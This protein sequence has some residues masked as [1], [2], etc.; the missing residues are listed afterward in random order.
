MSQTK[1]SQEE[2]RR[3]SAEYMLLQNLI[4]ELEQR[5][6]LLSTTINELMT[7]KQTINELSKLSKDH[8]LIVSV[9]RDVY[10]RVKVA[11]S[12]KFLVDLGAGTIVERSTEDAIKIIDSRIEDLRKAL[13]EYQRNYSVLVNRLAQIREIIE[14]ST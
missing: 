14:K 10:L 8:E 6:S 2:L 1:L 13:E 11:E 3:L 5:I 12:G 9:G 7:T 4:R